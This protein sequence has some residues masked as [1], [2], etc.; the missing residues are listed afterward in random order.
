M[1]RSVSAGVL[2]AGVGAVGTPIW[3][4]VGVFSYT[5]AACYVLVLVLVR[6]V[7]RV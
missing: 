3:V 2:T 6:V 1:L 7:R 5:G 4:W